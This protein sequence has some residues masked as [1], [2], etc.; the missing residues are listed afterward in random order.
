MLSDSKAFSESI[1]AIAELWKGK[2][3]N[4]KALKEE[5]NQLVT[6][7]R[8]LIQET[9]TVEQEIFPRAPIN[10]ENYSEVVKFYEEKL[11]EI[12]PLL[13]VN[14]YAAKIII[15]KKKFL[16]YRKFHVILTIM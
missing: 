11:N 8:R 7:S 3:Q 10:T 16:Y 1:K 9:V 13:T 4:Q 12:Q 2:I 14:D 5:W 6:N 15:K